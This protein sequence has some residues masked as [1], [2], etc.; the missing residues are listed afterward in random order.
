MKL[1]LAV[2]IDQKKRQIDGEADQYAAKKTT[3]THVSSV[4]PCEH[5]PADEPRGQRGQQRE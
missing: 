5:A 3:R 1:E 4:I 2:V